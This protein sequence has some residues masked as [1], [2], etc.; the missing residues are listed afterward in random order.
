MLFNAV[1]MNCTISRFLK[2]LSIMQSVLCCL[3]AELEGLVKFIQPF[4][5]LISKAKAAKMVRE[6]LD[7]FLDMEASTGT[8][9]YYISQV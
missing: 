2:H 4:M 9:V 7:L 5:L 6:L 8:E 3:I 1:A